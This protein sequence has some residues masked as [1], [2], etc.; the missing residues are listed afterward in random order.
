MT[1]KEFW[2]KL[3]MAK[4]KFDTVAECNPTLDLSRVSAYFKNIDD[5]IKNYKNDDRAG[6][7]Q[8]LPGFRDM[9]LFNLDRA[10]AV[11]AGAMELTLKAL[12]DA[13]SKK[14]HGR[15]P[16]DIVKAV[17][18]RADE[19]LR[20]EGFASAKRH[21]ERADFSFYLHDYDARVVSLSGL[22]GIKPPEVKT[23][24]SQPASRQEYF[25]RPLAVKVE[26]VAHKDATKPTAPAQEKTKTFTGRFVDPNASSVP[27]IDPSTPVL[28]M[29]TDLQRN[30]ISQRR[31]ASLSS[32]RGVVAER[33]G[34]KA[35]VS[36]AKRGKKG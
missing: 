33:V 36:R 1:R 23:K 31:M 34:S 22:A 35:A 7:Y 5:V 3:Q 18:L 28:G 26:K 4:K 11:L 24:K 21:M 6:R 29:S 10:E 8:T 13:F 19:V 12:K 2:E 20:M 9:A 27:M 15:I 16:T 30:R 25:Q 14:A 32:T 17:L